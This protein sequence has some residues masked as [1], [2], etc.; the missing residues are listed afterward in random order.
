MSLKL[1]VL[2]FFCVVFGGDLVAQSKA[3]VT[4]KVTSEPMD[5]SRN[6]VMSSLLF[7]RSDMEITFYKWKYCSIHLNAGKALDFNLIQD[8]KNERLIQV[9]ANFDNKSIKVTK[10]EVLDSIKVN[11][12]A[13][14]WE[15]VDETKVVAGYTCKKAVSDSS[16]CW[17]TNDLRHNFSQIDF[18]DVN[19][20]GFPL[21]FESTMGNVKSIFE[22]KK[23]EPLAKEKHKLIKNYLKTKEDN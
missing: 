11:N 3:T 23:I 5:T 16:V 10:Q 20:P 2:S 1:I 12:K 8:Y 4:Y 9:Y 18:V 7:N 6:A 15:L 22:A 21:V 19:L 17:Y 13:R 14:V